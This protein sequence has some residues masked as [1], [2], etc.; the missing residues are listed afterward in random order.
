MFLRAYAFKASPMQPDE[1]ARLC[2]D[3]RFAAGR[4]GLVAED[5]DGPR[6]TASA[7]LMRQNL[8]G[9]VYPMAGIAGVASHPLARRRGYVRALM[10][11]LLGRMRDEGYPVSTLYPFRPSFYERFGY[12]TLPSPR[13]A[14][15]APAGLRP[16]LRRE[17]PGEVSWARAGEGYQRYR[18]LALRLLEYRHGFAVFP[19]ERDRMAADNESHWLVLAQLDGSVPAGGLM[20]RIEEYSG[21]LHG[22]D[23][24]TT[25]PTSR[26]LLLRF[27]AGHTDQVGRVVVTV[28]PDDTP[29]LWGSDLTVHVEAA[30]RFPTNAAPMARVLSLELL[31][32][33]PTG[34]QG[35]TL[36]VVDDAWVGGTYRLAGSP[37][38]LEVT[39]VPNAEPDATL[40][41]AGLSAL[42][43]GAPDP[44]E[45][46]LLGWGSVPE[47]VAQRL[48]VLF[49]PRL[50]YLCARF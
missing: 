43:Y 6:A 49:P 21:T 42:V 12:A 3:P 28:A 27:L 5:D 39:R 47:P 2:S 13:T 36:T 15:F 25:G 33:L 34:E 45:F 16:L 7:V 44:A 30:V 20:Y 48:R 26:A 1:L 35:V 8:R 19:E 29:E 17:L 4:V 32:G 40:T 46:E 31:A 14:T 38:G 37:D 24:L 18:D 9:R 10:L 23:L 41:C 50:P 11:E 22:T